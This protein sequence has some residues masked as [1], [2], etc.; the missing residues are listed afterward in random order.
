MR[1]QLTGRMSPLRATTGCMILETNSGS[2]AA[3][4]SASTAVAQLSGTAIS[5]SF[6]KAANIKKEN[7]GSGK[8]APDSDIDRSVHRTTDF[9]TGS[10]RVPNFQREK[11]MS[12][13]CLARAQTLFRYESS[14][15]GGG[16]SRGDP[17][18]LDRIT[19]LENIATNNLL[20]M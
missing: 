20:A 9:R 8:Q 11:Q 16:Q 3:G 10:N 4:F 5:T 15:C 2:S 1:K 18:F 7:T 14:I 12:R 6:G 17:L 19:I 13:E